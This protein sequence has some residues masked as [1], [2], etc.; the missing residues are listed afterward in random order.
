MYQKSKKLALSLIVLTALG[1]GIATA[2]TLEAL[3]AEAAPIESKL[4]GCYSNI[5]FYELSD[6]ERVRTHAASGMIDNLVHR[7]A[8]THSLEGYD[9]VYMRYLVTVSELN[10]TRSKDLGC[11]SLFVTRTEQQVQDLAKRYG[12]IKGPRER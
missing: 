2:N 10:E 3:I 5:R 4:Q 8:K 12:S 1:S 9:E 11:D 7:H 6:E